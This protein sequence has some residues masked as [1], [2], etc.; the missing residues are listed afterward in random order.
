M[1]R[2]RFQKT[3]DGVFL[4]HLDLMRV[5]QRAFARA[6]LM[7]KHSQG[8]S[9]R[10]YVSVALPLSVGVESECEL[11]DYELESGDAPA[12]LAERLNATMPDGVRVLK[13]YESDKK[14]K[15]IAFLRAEVTLEYD[16]GVP[17]GAGERIESLLAGPELVV[18]KHT[19]KGEADV[20]VRPMIRQASVRQIGPG[21]LVIDATV[22]AQNPGLNP[23]LLAQAVERYLPDLTPD[24]ARC[25]RREIFDESGAPF[26]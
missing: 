11:L 7:L 25:C 13:A 10:A 1:L 4:S 20:D 21:E 3:G 2:L 26:R 17:D 14:P 24:F 22:S 18:A 15:E 23:M 12:D 19:K 8:F 9:P 16:G 6:G 5:F